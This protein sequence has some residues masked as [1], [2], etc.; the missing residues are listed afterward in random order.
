MELAIKTL[1]DRINED[2]A[3][4]Q[5]DLAHMDDLTAELTAL[6]QRIQYRRDRLQ[7]N[8]RAIETIERAV[9]KLPVGSA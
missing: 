4:E 3:S 9:K 2:E 8:R 6:R 5:A 7:Q 1:T